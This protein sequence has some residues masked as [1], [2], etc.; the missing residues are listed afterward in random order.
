M[1]LQL[2][3]QSTAPVSQRSRIRF[4]FSP[5]FF[6]GFN[7]TTAQVMCITA[8]ISHIFLRTQFLRSRYHFESGMAFFQTYDYAR[9]VEVYLFS[10]YLHTTY[11]IE[12]LQLQVKNGESISIADVHSRKWMSRVFHNFNGSNNMIRIKVIPQ[13]CTAHP[14]CARFLRHQRVHVQNERN[15]PQAELNSEINV[16]FLLNEHGYL[17]LFIA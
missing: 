13:Y 17:Y 10:V 1:A 11:S 2:S 8:M 12:E 14:Y 7:F 3:W 9:L 16:H 5:E 6:P 15:F 4:P